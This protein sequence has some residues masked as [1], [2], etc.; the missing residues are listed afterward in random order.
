VGRAIAEVKQCGF[1]GCY[2]N[3]CHYPGNVYFVP[4]DALLAD[5]SLKLGVSAA[6]G[7]FGDVVPRAF[8]K[9]KVITHQ[10]VTEGRLSERTVARL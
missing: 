5:E 2:D 6:S 10:L 8:V 3:K 9:T 7:L 1:G 4:N